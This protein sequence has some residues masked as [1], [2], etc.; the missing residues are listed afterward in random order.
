MSKPKYEIRL[1]DVS[2]GFYT[3]NVYKKILGIFWWPV[4]SSESMD[5]QEA[6]NKCEL[7]LMREK[8]DEK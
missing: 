7:Y 2:E 1:S 6:L 5:K 3:Y 8:F 4:F